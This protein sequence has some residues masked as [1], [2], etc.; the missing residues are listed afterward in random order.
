M[1]KY[2]TIQGDMWDVISLRAYGTEKQVAALIDA[3]YFHKNTAVFSA[4]VVLNIPDLALPKSS[5][6]PPWKR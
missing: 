1:R 4:G 2:T 3:N 5:Q 6:L